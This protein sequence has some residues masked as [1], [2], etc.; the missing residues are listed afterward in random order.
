MSEEALKMDK[1]KIRHDDTGKGQKSINE[2]TI[3]TKKRGVERKE[4]KI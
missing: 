2:I 4:R 1:N 3:E